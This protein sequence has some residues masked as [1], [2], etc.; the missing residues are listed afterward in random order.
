MIVSRKEE[1]FIT[2]NLGDVENG[3]VELMLQSVGEDTEPL[4]VHRVQLAEFQAEHRRLTEYVEI[5][6][7]CMFGKEPEV[8]EAIRP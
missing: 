3:D 5:V 7:R 2:N 6:V 8:S 4:S 1:E